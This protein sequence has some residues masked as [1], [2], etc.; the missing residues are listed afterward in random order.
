MHF[1]HQKSYM[2]LGLNARQN[3]PE[4]N[5]LFLALKGLSAWT[6]CNELPAVLGADAIAYSTQTK[7]LRQRQFTS[8]FV[9]P[10]EEPATIVIDQAI[11]GALEQYPFSSTWELICLTCIP[12]TTIHRHLT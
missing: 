2:T 4:I 9:D 10:P 1:F 6:V 8:I 7:Y 5:R 11:L 12:T 3:G